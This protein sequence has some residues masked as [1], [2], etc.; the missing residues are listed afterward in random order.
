MNR[1]WLMVAII[2]VVL[3]GLAP[4]VSAYEA[5]I[6]NVKARVEQP[7]DCV[8]TMA[9]YQ[10]NIDLDN[11]GNLSPSDPGNWPNNKPNPSWLTDPANVPTFNQ[12]TWLVT[13][14]VENSDDYP[15]HNVYLK[16][17]FS[18]ELAGEPLG[19]LPVDLTIIKHT[20]G[21]AKKK[22]F[23]TQ[24]RIDWYVT[25]LYLPGSDVENPRPGDNDGILLPGEKAILQVLVWTKL[26]P[27][28]RQEY[29][30]PGKYTLNS[31]PSM[32][33]ED[34]SNRQWSAVAP[35]LYVNAY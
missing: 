4:L 29:T 13:L 28:G 10:G 27:S 24:Y 2:G 14:E 11:D 33:W 34:P 12:I 3:V 16:D 20:A 26:N 7:H 35:S 5:H 18:A 15:W 32:K 25:W 17:N 6:V 19:G 30:T 31:G 21:A 8:K 22:L 1:K 9:L 23:E